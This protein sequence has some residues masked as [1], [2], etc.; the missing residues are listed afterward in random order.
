MHHPAAAVTFPWR[1]CGWHIK[2]PSDGIVV[3]AHG[4]LRRQWAVGRCM[5]R[6]CIG[7]AGSH[8]QAMRIAKHGHATLPGLISCRARGHTR[9]AVVDQK[10]AVGWRS[11][12]CVAEAFTTVVESEAAHQCSVLTSLLGG[13]GRGWRMGR[14]TIRYLKMVGAR[15]CGVMRCSRQVRCHEAV[16]P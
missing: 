16:K 15:M 10:D 8:C 9:L 13:L 3:W 11:K 7:V 4:R 5:G 12:I 1:H 2:E 14:D 6:H